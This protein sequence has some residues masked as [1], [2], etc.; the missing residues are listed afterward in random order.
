MDQV[1]DV[2]LMH[3]RASMN[4]DHR[5]EIWF[6]VAMTKRETFDFQNVPQ[7]FER[8]ILKKERK[9]TVLWAFKQGV[10]CCHT[11]IRTF[12]GMQSTMQNISSYPQW[13]IVK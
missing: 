2:M 8:T 7:L 6:C 4:Y 12:Y 10:P 3:V 11:F 5:D 9:I 1:I 13:F